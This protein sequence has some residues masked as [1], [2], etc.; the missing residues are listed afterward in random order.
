MQLGALAELLGVGDRREVHRQQLVARVAGDLAH[1]IVGLQ[2][3]AVGRRDRHPHRRVLEGG[4]EALARGLDV[5]LDRAQLGHV[6]GG[7]DEHS[8]PVGVGAA[9]RMHDPTRA[10]GAC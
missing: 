7:A 2:H 4:A 8:R 1:R 9:E 5:A 10:I 3:A 6:L